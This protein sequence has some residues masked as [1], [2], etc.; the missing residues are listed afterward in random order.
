MYSKSRMIL[1]NLNNFI[2]HNIDQNNVDL[3]PLKKYY[4]GY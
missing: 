2:N 4:N 3:S 1:I